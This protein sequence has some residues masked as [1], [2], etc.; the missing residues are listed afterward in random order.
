[1]ENDATFT[2]PAAT[3]TDRVRIYVPRAANTTLFGRLK[4]TGP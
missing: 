1:V 4:V 3:A 2:P